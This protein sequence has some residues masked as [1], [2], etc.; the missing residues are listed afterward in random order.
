MKLNQIF[1]VMAMLGSV[2][3][4]LP[5]LMASPPKEVSTNALIGT[6]QGKH[7]RATLKLDLED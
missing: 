5:A 2:M 6:Y 4:Q 7:I 3:A 1:Q